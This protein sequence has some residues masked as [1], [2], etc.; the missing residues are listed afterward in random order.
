MIIEFTLI[1]SPERLIVQVPKAGMTLDLPNIMAY[2]RKGKYV[3]AVG[4]IGDDLIRECGNDWEKVKHEIDFASAFS[5]RPLRLG[6]DIADLQYLSRKAYFQVRP[7]PIV[8]LIAAAFLDRFDY[9]LWLEDYEQ[10][11]GDLRI[12]FEYVLQAEGIAGT[13]KLSIN[14]KAVE[15]AEWKRNLEKTLRFILAQVL[16]LIPL[17]VWLGIVVNQ[18]PRSRSAESALANLFF[19]F[20]VGMASFE[21]TYLLAKTVWILTMRN[22]VPKG[23]LRFLLPKLPSRFANR[24]LSNLLLRE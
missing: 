7:N 22:L 13:R 6:Y 23:Y 21:L 19:F 15:I 17:L 5:F 4:K 16:P 10:L 11:P 20:V 9:D 12:V 14:G 1:T 18:L 2:A 8:R 24:Q 3:V